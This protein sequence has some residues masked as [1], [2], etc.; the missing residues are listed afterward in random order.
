MCI[1]SPSP[2]PFHFHTMH[3]SQDKVNS[4]LSSVWSFTPLLSL[5]GNCLIWLP[6][7]SWLPAPSC[8]ISQVVLRQCK[9]T[10]N[11]SKSIITDWVF[12]YCSGL[13]PCPIQIHSIGWLNNHLWIGETSKIGT[14]LS[15]VRDNRGVRSVDAQKIHF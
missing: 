12:I 13:S 5:P 2:I 9:G 1:C 14:Q 11:I 6:H 7:I 8:P 10:E 3:S 15:I 4:Q